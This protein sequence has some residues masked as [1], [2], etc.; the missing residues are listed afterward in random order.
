MTAATSLRWFRLF[1]C[2]FIVLIAA[3]LPTAPAFAVTIDLGLSFTAT[4]GS[5]SF[6]T[7]NDNFTLPAGFS[8]ASL[9][10][11]TL[12]LDDRGVVVLNGTIIT[13]AGI[14][15]PGSGFMTLT[16]GGSN[17]PFTFTHGNG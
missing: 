9:T 6:Y 15:G 7:L 2:G 13:N 17:N 3:T 1:S 8:N 11:Q 12:D 14:F 10:I 5:P 16:N 4:F